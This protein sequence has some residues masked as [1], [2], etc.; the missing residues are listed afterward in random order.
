MRSNLLG[1]TILAVAWLKLGAGATAE[2]RPPALTEDQIRQMIR[3]VAEKDQENDKKQRDY[4]CVERD[5]ERTLDGKGHVKSTEIKTYEVMDLY[6]DQVQRLI[7]KDDKPL[8]DQ[9]ARK[10]EKKIQHLMEKRKNE[11]EKDRAK[12]QEKEEKDREDGRKF[13]GDVADAFNFRLERTE[14]LN[15][16]ETYVISAEPRPG[17]HPHSRETGFL[18]KVRFRAWI[19]KD[20]LQWKKADIQ[21]IDTVSFGLILARL[22]KGSRVVIEQARVNDEVWLPQHIEVRV[23][24]RLA[25]LK[26][27]NMDLDFTFRDYKKFRSDSRLIVGTEQPEAGSQSR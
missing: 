23:D 26:G 24:A 19:D 13:M 25:L 17:Y 8:S 22:H 1:F 20:E 27:L 15:G 11:S 18:P 4:T 6:G 7:A 14:Q 9:D 16:R 21:F 5:E 2:E 3:Q 12:R 10:E